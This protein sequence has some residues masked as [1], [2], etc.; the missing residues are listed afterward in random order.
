MEFSSRRIDIYQRLA[1]LERIC[2]GLKPA[3]ELS[4]DDL[5]K[6]WQDAKFF[7]QL[8]ELGFVQVSY[9]G[10]EPID[11]V[12]SAANG[13]RH[14]A[15]ALS[16]FVSS[17][18]ADSKAMVSSSHERGGFFNAIFTR[19]SNDSIEYVNENGN[20]VQFTFDSS[21]PSQFI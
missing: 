20:K 10:A 18:Y 2:D 1:F 15:L 5:Y 12:P 21:K 8:A 7:K 19:I 14:Q 9:N 11:F 13:N 4:F 17:T 6:R 3:H 16:C